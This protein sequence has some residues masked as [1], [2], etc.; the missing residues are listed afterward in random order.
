MRLELP[1][2]CLA[3]I[4][5]EASS[6]CFYICFKHILKDIYSVLR[7][8]LFWLCGYTCIMSA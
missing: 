7:E 5:E 8:Q 4:L 6:F 2:S 1:V 3:F